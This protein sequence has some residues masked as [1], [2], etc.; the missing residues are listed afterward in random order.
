MDG[1]VDLWVCTLPVLHLCMEPSPPTKDAGVQPED[2]W[3][4]LE[5][6]SFSEFREKKSDR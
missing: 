4:A 3:A 6:I 1:E 2:T 5:G